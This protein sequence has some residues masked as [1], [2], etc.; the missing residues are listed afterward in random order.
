MLLLSDMETT[1]HSLPMEIAIEGAVFHAA[2]GWFAQEKTVGNEFIVDLRVTVDVDPSVARAAEA[3]TDKEMEDLCATVSYADLFEEVSEAMRTPRRLIETV[4]ADV[5]RR[6]SVRF[7][8]IREGEVK[9]TKIHPP[10]P[11]MEGSA[12]V[13][14][15]F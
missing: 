12:S 5:A 2:H 1:D 7:P 15:K 4:A 13:K 6:V 3:V 8:K 10:I 11:R 9:I 14:L